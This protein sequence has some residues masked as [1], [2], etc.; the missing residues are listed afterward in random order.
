MELYGDWKVKSIAAIKNGDFV[1]LT[2]NEVTEDE[3][4]QD[5]GFFF[6][7]IF[8]VSPLQIEALYKPTQEELDEG[9]DVEFPMTKEGYGLIETYAAEV[10]EDG[11][12]YAS[13]E[14]SDDE[15]IYKKAEI[16]ENGEFLLNNVFVLTKI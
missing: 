8:R 15:P 10:R 12:Y 9:F 5:Y 6:K 14:L 3:D 11:Y 4:Y 16:N 7:C 1:Y 13:G 2:E